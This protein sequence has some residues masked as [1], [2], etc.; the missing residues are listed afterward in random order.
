M[1]FAT[2]ISEAPVAALV[3]PT[4]DDFEQ[5][6]FYAA[7]GA[8]GDGNIQRR[9]SLRQ[10]DDDRCHGDAS[11]ERRPAAGPIL[12]GLEDSIEAQ[13][14]LPNPSFRPFRSP[15]A[16]AERES[17]ESYIGR[18]RDAF[19]I[20]ASSSGTPA[21]AANEVLQEPFSPEGGEEHPGDVILDAAGILCNFKNVVMDEHCT[22]QDAAEIVDLA[23]EMLSDEKPQEDDDEEEYS[24]EGEERNDNYWEYC[25]PSN[26]AFARAFAE[27]ELVAMIDSLVHPDRLATEDDSEEVNKLHQYVR[28]DLLEI[29]V[30]PQAATADNSDDDEDEEGSRGKKRPCGGDN[31]AAPGTI[32]RTRRRSIAISHAPAPSASAQRHYPGRVGLRCVHC[33]DVRRKSTTSKAAFYPLRLKNIY[34][35]V[36]AWQRIHFKRCPHVPADVRERYDRYKRIDPSRGKVRYWETSARRIGLRNNPDRDDGVVFAQTAWKA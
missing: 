13:A 7:D 28:K 4:I 10:R 3:T 35:E 25:P 8:D 32:R 14:A 16:A 30:V 11:E 2:K 20:I 24:M 31:A 12:P 9:V 27:N 29:F 1:P 23:V 26:G 17:L 21:D 33:A 18:D 34:R 22:P 5:A 15:V 19:E 36:C 6:A